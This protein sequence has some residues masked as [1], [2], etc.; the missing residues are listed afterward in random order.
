[1]KSAGLVVALHKRK[2][3]ETARKLTAFLTKQRVAIRALPEVA[4]KL[5]HTDWSA[6]FAAIARTDLVVVLGG[7]GSVLSTARATA[8]RRTPILAVEVGGFGFL[9]E[10][11]PSALHASV[12]RFATGDF[13]LEER[14]MLRATVT[15]AGKVAAACEGLN[16]AVITKGAFSR[17]LK[18]RTSVNGQFVANYPAD[19]LIVA[20]PTG[21][22]A[23]SLS[24]GGP[25]I[26]PDERLLLI[27]PICA[28]TLFARPL[29][30]GGDEEVRVEVT[31]P[32]AENTQ[33]MLTV[34][35]QVGVPLQ[36]GDTVTFRRA[37]HSARFVRF[38]EHAFYAR[39]RQKLKWGGEI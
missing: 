22:T 5:G 15:R 37:R 32:A 11:K 16:D 6:D 31:L 18:L 7:D 38:G 29:V 20:T 27:T 26:H 21:S 33:V 39:L 13:R 28:H 36:H 2:A 25:I 17:L 8:P 9:N 35:G 23:Y 24:A 19:G 34:D 10:V 12:Q 14:M 4:S 1:M 30:V 3:A